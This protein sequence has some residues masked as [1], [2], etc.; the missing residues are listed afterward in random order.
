VTFTPNSIPVNI[1]DGS[2]GSFST[3]LSGYTDGEEVCFLV[4]LLDPTFEICCTAEVCV[5]PDCDCL[6]VRRRTIVGSS[7]TRSRVTTPSPS[8]STTSPGATIYHAYLFPPAGV[9]MT[10]NYFAFP[11]GRA[12]PDLDGADHRRHQRGPGRASSASTSTL[13]DE[14]LIE[15]CGREVCI[16]LPPC[17]VGPGGG[18]SADG[19]GAA[20]LRG[21]PWVHLDPGLSAACGESVNAVLTI[22]NNGDTP[23]SFEWV[24]NA[25]EAL[26]CDIAMDPGS[27]QPSSGQ[28]GVLDPGKCVDITLVIDTRDVPLD[29]IGCL[30]AAIVDLADGF[31]T[32]TLGQVIAPQM[33]DDVQPGVVLS[34]CPVDQGRVVPI[35]LG[36]TSE[37]AFDLFADQSGEIDWVIQTSN[38]F[39]ALD[40]GEPGTRI[41]G[42]SSVQAGA[43]TRVSVQATLVNNPG[44]WIMDVALNARLV[45]PYRPTRPQQLA[46]VSVRDAAMERCAG[47]FNADG[48]LDLADVNAFVNAFVGR[49][50]QGDLD[51]NGVWDLGDVNRFVD[52]FLAGCGV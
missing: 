14:A 49:L 12:R 22:I 36:E 19:T 31:A 16:E 21:A 27:V 1:P 38:P 47:D 11:G 17:Q 3:Q 8:R 26:G 50:P 45:G 10:P 42:T 28:T 9:T 24:I 32:S 52:L 33:L 51:G 39:L 46:S 44:A 7:A 13:H 4:T 2:S 48:V 5:T 41:E 29:A 34:A 6:Q 40:G 18:T 35:G 30:E 23:R 43:P 20:L 37:I 25:G 15:C